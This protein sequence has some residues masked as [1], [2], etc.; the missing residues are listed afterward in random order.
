M[1]TATKPTCKVTP[2]DRM[3]YTFEWDGKPAYVIVETV[4]FADLGDGRTKVVNLSLFRT[5]EERDDM[6]QSGMEEGLNQRYVALDRLRARWADGPLP[7]VPRR[8]EG[9]QDT[10]RSAPPQVRG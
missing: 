1:S 5:T 6:L 8:R 3:V 9:R 10:P 4:E 7:P 2:Q